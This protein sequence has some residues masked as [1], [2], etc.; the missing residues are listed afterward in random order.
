MPN[1]TV[2]EGPP[3]EAGGDRSPALGI[4]EIRAA[5]E[6]DLAAIVAL[7]NGFAPDGLTLMRTP[8]FVE[9]HLGDYRVARAPHGGIWG[10][11]ALDEYSPSLVEL[12]S[13]AVSS[14][15]HGR[16]LGKRLVAAAEELARRRGYA[17]MF[18]I[19][20]SEA[21]FVGLG[22]EESS[23]VHYP[24]K[25][26]RYAN[27]SRSELAMGRKFCFVKRLAGKEG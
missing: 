20:F 3:P 11:V 10:C 1:R 4:V 7:N 8:E 15:A 25:Q 13:L 21:F 12:I 17:E 2:G 9:T 16:G 27:V 24:E 14:E 23:I 6:T 19:S 18:A 22:Y 26:A 5:R